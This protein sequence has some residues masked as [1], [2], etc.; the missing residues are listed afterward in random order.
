MGRCESPMGTVGTL[1]AVARTP[2]L[3][4]RQNVADLGLQKM[5]T[6]GIAVVPPNAPAGSVQTVATSM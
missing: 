3:S 6:V 1:E 2:R 5:V 4:S